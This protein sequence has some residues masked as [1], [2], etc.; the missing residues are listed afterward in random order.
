MKTSVPAT[1][2]Q[3]AFITKLIGERVVDDEHAHYLFNA[4][5]DNALGKFAASKEIESL[6]SK[7]KKE[8]AST[9]PGGKSAM[10][11]EAHPGY[12]TDGTRFYEVVQSKQGNKYAKELTVQMPKCEGHADGP[13]MGETFYCDGTCNKKGKATWVYRPGVM[14][15]FQTWLPVDA[16][17]AA[18][19]GKMFGAC[20]VCGRTLTDP[21]SVEAGIGPVCAGKF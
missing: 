13:V 7:P 2:K 4:M 14:K 19:F 12:Y 15:A 5:E 18:E 1:E 17:Q 16:A 11:K 20:F 10:N 9:A 3:V 8:Q 21:K 6:L